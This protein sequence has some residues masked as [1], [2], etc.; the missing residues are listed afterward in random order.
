MGE[1]TRGVSER[2]APA[3]APS[4]IAVSEIAE[5]AR[6]RTLDIVFTFRV[7]VSC[8]GLTQIPAMYPAYRPGGCPAGLVLKLLVAEAAA[9]YGKPG[10]FF[11]H[12]LRAYGAGAAAALHPSEIRCNRRFAVA[13][14][15]QVRLD[16]PDSSGR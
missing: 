5:K 2:M 7:E 4:R 9:S 11:S 10:I 8:R 13:A 12:F 14:K 3:V 1:R 15:R 16:N 6:R